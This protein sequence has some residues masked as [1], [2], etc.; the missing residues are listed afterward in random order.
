MWND[1][2]NKPGLF[3]E[4]VLHLSP[5]GAAKFGRLLSEAVRKFWTEN[6]G[7]SQGVRPAQ[8]L[9]SE[10]QRGFQTTPDKPCFD[11][12]ASNSEKH[13]TKSFDQ[14]SILYTNA[15]SIILKRNHLLA[16]ATAEKPDFIMITESWLNIRDKHLLSEAAITGYNIF[17]KSRLQKMVEEY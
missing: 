16:H 15:R 3:K 2:Y 9:T 10:I 8:K 14:M 11:I 13:N 4:D 6:G 7:S 5:V 17:E 1:F 12:L